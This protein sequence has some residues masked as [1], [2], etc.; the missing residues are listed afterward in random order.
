M[1]RH[2]VRP[3]FLGIMCPVFLTI[4]CGLTKS[5]P[6]TGPILLPVINGFAS[7]AQARRL[8]FAGGQPYAAWNVQSSN[9]GCIARWG[10]TNWADPFTCPLPT[11]TP[12]PPTPTPIP[13]PI[14]TCSPT[15]SGINWSWNN[16]AGTISYWLQVWDDVWKANGWGYTSP[17]FTGGT[18]G[19]TYNGKVAAGDGT[20]TSP[21]ST[22]KSCKVPDLPKCTISA[23]PPNIDYYSAS[24]ITWSSTDATSCSVLPP[25]WTGTSGSQNTDNLTTTTTYRIL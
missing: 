16:L 8:P 9:A 3:P 5:L 10:I 11:P 14:L 20:Q 13:P 19:V 24:T 25:G 17:T 15:F 22:T 12:I 18:P 4:F 21:W 2:M 6:A 1:Y 7:T 23:N